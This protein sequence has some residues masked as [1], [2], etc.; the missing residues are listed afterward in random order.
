[1][2]KGCG[3][4]LA[5]HADRMDSAAAVGLIVTHMAKQMERDTAHL[6][7]MRRAFILTASIER[8]LAEKGYVVQADVKGRDLTLTLD[9]PALFL[10]HTLAKLKRLSGPVAG[11]HAVHTRIGRGFYRAD[12][13][14]QFD[15]RIPLRLIHEREKRWFARQYV[16]ESYVL[17]A[18]LEKPADLSPDNWI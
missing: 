11:K 12:I 1:M 10:S 5:I 16:G 2:G 6:D 7:A 3:E 9:Q 8:Y 13:C 15:F 18:S 17:P 4:D 14:H